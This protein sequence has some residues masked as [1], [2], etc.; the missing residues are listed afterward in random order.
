MIIKSSKYKDLKHPIAM[1]IIYMYKQYQIY[2]SCYNLTS[3]YYKL[4]GTPSKT[5]KTCFL[6][7]FNLQICIYIYIYVL[8]HIAGDPHYYYYHNTSEYLYY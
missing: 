2:C 1:Y 4:R 5:S 3:V 7:D 6:C 8:S